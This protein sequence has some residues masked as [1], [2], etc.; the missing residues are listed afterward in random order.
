M[1]VPPPMPTYT[2]APAIDHLSAEQMD[3][4]ERCVCSLTGQV[5]TVFI[6]DLRFTERQRSMQATSSVG[7]L[8]IIEI[9]SEPATLTGS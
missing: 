2:L 5:A 4:V 7:D 3:F 6:S 1:L 8:L 9:L